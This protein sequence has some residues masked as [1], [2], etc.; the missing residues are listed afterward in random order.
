MRKNIFYLPPKFPYGNLQ[1]VLQKYSLAEKLDQVYFSNEDQKA[2]GVWA[3]PT[4]LLVPRDLEL[5]KR[6]L[7]KDFNSF[8]DRGLIQAE[9]YDPLTG[10]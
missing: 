7:I 4:P 8:M 1:G 6:I 5:V 3:F 9:D 2:I 10:Q